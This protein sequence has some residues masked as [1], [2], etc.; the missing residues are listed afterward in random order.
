MSKPGVLRTTAS[1]VRRITPR[2]H[3][4]SRTQL[5]KGRRTLFPAESTIPRP[6]SLGR[7]GV[8][9]DLFDQVALVSFGR[10]NMAGLRPEH[11]VLDIGCGIGRMARYLCDYLEP[12]SRYEGFDVIEESVRWCQENITPLFHNFGFRFTPLFNALYNADPQLPSA[13]QFRFPY[14]DECFDFVFA[15]SIFTH[16]QPDEARNYL[17]EIARV[18]RRGG[19]SYNT[20]LL[21]SD[22]SPDYRHSIM[23]KMQRDPSGSFALRRTDVPGRAVAYDEAF[24]LDAYESSGLV[25]AGRIHPGFLIQD[26]I[27]AAKERVPQPS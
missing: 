8:G 15:H 17:R 20:W 7:Y 18:L 12:S 21:Y 27:V 16:L 25:L 5:P 4:D 22:G 6:A 2:T 3:L 10:L 11:D 13:A 1:R 23:S 24:V 14:P 19:T 26:A 9:K